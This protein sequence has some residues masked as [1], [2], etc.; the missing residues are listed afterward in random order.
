MVGK[1]HS[2]N[3]FLYMISPI[4]D[5]LLNILLCWIYDVWGGKFHRNLE[6]SKHA[7]ASSHGVQVGPVSAGNRSAP[8]G[9]PGGG[10]GGLG[11]AH[12]HVHILRAHTGRFQAGQQKCAKV[13]Y[14]VGTGAEREGCI[15]HLRVSSYSLY[16]LLV[17]MCLNHSLHTDQDPAGPR[18]APSAFLTG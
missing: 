16:L 12:P 1:K 3:T 9:G 4:E 11:G 18:T 14:F 15:L 8:L 17:F 2:I 5:T 6:I 10:G 7:P 13:G